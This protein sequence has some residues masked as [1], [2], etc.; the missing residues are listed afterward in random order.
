MAQSRGGADHHLFNEGGQS[1]LSWMLDIHEDMI[2]ASKTDLPFAMPVDEEWLETKEAFMAALLQGDHRRCLDLAETVVSS[3]EDV[4]R[5]Y[6]Q[7]L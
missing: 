2:A 6:L 4:A 3:H 1:V 7:I 5:F